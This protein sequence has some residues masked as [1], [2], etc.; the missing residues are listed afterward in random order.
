MDEFIQ[1]YFDK[2]CESFNAYT[3]TSFTNKKERRCW[4]KLYS[5][6]FDGDGKDVLNVGCGP[7][8]EAL[9]LAD[10]GFRVTGL[11]FSTNM[12]ETARYNSEKYGVKYGVILGDA[13]DLP[14]KN[15][16]FDFIASN[17]ALWAI[18]D[19]EKSMKEWLRVLRPGGKVAYVE[20]VWNLKDPSFF[21]KIW[22][23]IAVR[24]RKKDGNG[25]TYDLTDEEKEHL[26]NLWSKSAE[27]PKDD[28]DMMH[29]AG[30]SKVE[31]INKVDRRIFK[32]LRYIEY[33][34]H[35]IHFMIIGTK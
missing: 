25:H 16:S 10:M 7:G 3:N 34:Y 23:K 11:D 28:L 26:A 9:V 12:V 35:P 2:G 30:F 32:G 29:S 13:M 6:V 21:R 24:M 31:I 27:R 5:E 15:D 1:S 4:Q 33:G 8:T 14:F 19:P 22:V 17:Y 18:P 20:G